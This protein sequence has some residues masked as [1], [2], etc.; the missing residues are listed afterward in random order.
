MRSVLAFT[1]RRYSE[2]LNTNGGGTKARAMMARSF[3]VQ[4]PLVERPNVAATLLNDYADSLLKCE[5][6]EL[7]D[8]SK[9]LEIMLKVD[10]LT[11]GA[12]PLFLDTLAWA[13]YR[14][15]DIGKSIATEKKALSLLP[16]NQQSGIRTEIERG[17]A[18]FES[19]RKRQ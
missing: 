17:L 15:N 1:L 2:L 19:A 12:N 4:R 9:A 18:E 8:A 5:Y 3:E 16:P 6:P 10:Q 13:Y 14:N 11:K 7:R